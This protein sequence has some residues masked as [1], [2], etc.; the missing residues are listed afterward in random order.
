ME[1]KKELAKNE[2]WYGLKPIK[3]YFWAVKKVLGDLNFDD[4]VIKGKGKNISN[5]CS[6]AMFSIRNLPNIKLV[7]IKLN[8]VEYEKEGFKKFVTEV[9]V[10]LAKNKEVKQ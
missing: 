1:E 2:I 9:E 6:L 4:V 3:N 8:E 5:V 10:V 7:S